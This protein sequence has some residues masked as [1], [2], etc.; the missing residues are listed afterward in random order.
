MR[1]FVLL[2]VTLCFS[3]LISGN[4]NAACSKNSDGEFVVTGTGFSICRGDAQR[5]IYEVTDL[6]LCEFLPQISETSSQLNNC[7][8]VLK[9][10]IQVD[11]E[12]GEAQTAGA[13]RRPKNGSY[14]YFYRITDADGQF[15][16]VVKYANSVRAGT[17]SGLAGTTNGTFCQAPDYPVD[18]DHMYLSKPSYA[19]HC[20]AS[21][22]AS[23]RLSTVRVHNFFSNSFEPILVV[24]TPDATTSTSN[25]DPNAYQ[26]VYLLDAD[27]HLASS[28]DEVDAML[29]IIRKDSPIEISESTNGINIGFSLTD[30]I[31]A[32]THVVSGITIVT[33]IVLNGRTVSVDVE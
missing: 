11:L 16:G 6:G 32:Y 8:K 26:N 33:Q 29:M 1:T 25:P 7:E 20:T 15:Q 18:L 31:N 13:V 30:A 27:G 3:V 17:E 22:P 23:A 12:I 2:T 21:E 24:A 28:R 14:R 19:S 9:E 5:M 4:A 10:K